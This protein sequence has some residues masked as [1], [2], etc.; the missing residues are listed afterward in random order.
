VTSRKSSTNGGRTAEFDDGIEQPWGTIWREMRGEIERSEWG[1][2]RN[3]PLVKWWLKSPG[4]K[5]RVN[6]KKLKTDEVVR[7]VIPWL[8]LEDDDVAVGPAH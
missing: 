4:I 1:L 6:A 8:R 2:S 5:S 7:A 3:K